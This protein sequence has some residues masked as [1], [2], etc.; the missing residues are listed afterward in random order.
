[1]ALAESGP[2][3]LAT[4]HARSTEMG[5]QKMLRLLGNLDAQSQALAHALR[6]VLCQALLPSLDDNRYHLATE[7]LTLNP[8]LARLIE[9]GDLGGLRAHMNSG[10]DPGCHTMN[11]SLERL[12][13]G[14]RISVEDARNAT[15][16][17]V[18]FA[19]LV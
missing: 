9:A 11:A 3:V 12:L 1:L 8:A 2:L 14:H 4:L 13:A 15:T 10:R 5:L 19:N 6:G 16:D 7:C 18:G 17:R